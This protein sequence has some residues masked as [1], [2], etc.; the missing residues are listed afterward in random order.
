MKAMGLEK[1]VE[2]LKTQLKL[3][4]VMQCDTKT[5]LT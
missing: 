4:E 3:S 1:E 2:I 5:S